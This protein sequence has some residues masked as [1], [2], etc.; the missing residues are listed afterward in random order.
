MGRI[1]II[2]KSEN[3]RVPLCHGM[4]MVSFVKQIID[5]VDKT[6]KENLF[7]YEGKNNKKVKDINTALYLANYDRGEEEYSVHGD[8]IINL[9]FYNEEMFYYLYNGALKVK[10]LEYKGYIFNVKKVNVNVENKIQGKGVV[11]KT[12]SPI[13]IKNKEGM[14][15]DVSDSSYIESLNYIADITLKNIR[16]Y[17][18][19][20]P[21]KFTPLNYKKVVVKEKISKFKERDFYY[22]NAYKGSFFLQGNVED[23]NALYK[24]GIGYRR[25]ENSGMVSVLQ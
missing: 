6:M 3:N 17:G 1:S 23:L 19:K 18:L 20:E 2:T 12:L 22:I 7:Y 16:G 9:S 5:A 24:T 4:M 25:T 8:V 21:L 10:Q 15:L 11:F 14:Y 13:V